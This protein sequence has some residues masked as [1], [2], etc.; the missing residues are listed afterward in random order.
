[1]NQVDKY[2]ILQNFY[3]VD[4]V[5]NIIAKDNIVYDP[6]S[7]LIS[8]NVKLGKKNVFYSN[9]IIKNDSSSVLIINDSNVFSSNVC[10]VAENGGEVNVGNNNFFDN[11]PISVKANINTSK[12]VFKDDGRYDGKINIYGICEFGSGS[13]ILGNINIYNC[14]LKS[15]FSFRHPNPDERAGL[16][17]GCGTAKDLIVP[18]GK[19]ING[20]NIFDQNKLENQSTYHPNKKD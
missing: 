20:R 18:K 10:I 14:K 4:E 11:G 5:I 7:L 1:M 12:I 16:I 2:R 19:V 13:Q 15:G 9:V 8:K 6:Y 3:T 17:K